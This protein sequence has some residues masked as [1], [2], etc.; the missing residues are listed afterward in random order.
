MIKLISK[1]LFLLLLISTKAYAIELQ[2]MGTFGRWVVYKN[3][4]ENSCHA[5]SRPYRSALFSGLRST[6]FIAVSSANQ[7]YSITAYPGFTINPTM[8]TTMQIGLKSYSL[9]TV[10]GGYALTYSPQQDQ[11]L[12]K[13]LLKNNRSFRVHAKSI[14]DKYSMDFYTT[15]H[16]KDALD[17]MQKSDCR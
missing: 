3:L 10:Y 1:F 11:N 8:N 13:Y 15:E 16:L 12:L 6:P 4:A 9:E 17:F 14:N 2:E 5:I 7:A